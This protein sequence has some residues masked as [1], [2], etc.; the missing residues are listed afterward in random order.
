MAFGANNLTF[1][2]FPI[3]DLMNQRPI[4]KVRIQLLEIGLDGMVNE[5]GYFVFLNIADRLPKNNTIVITSF[6]K[7]YRDM[8]FTVSKDKLIKQH[9]ITTKL[10]PSSSYPFS[11]DETLIR[12]L[13][14]TDVDLGDGNII[15][16]PV[17]GAKVKIFERGIESVTDERGEYVI[18]F[19]SLSKED[20]DYEE[21]FINM[22]FDTKFDLVINS[23]GFREFRHSNIQIEV[24]KTTVINAK[25]L[26]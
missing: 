16:S 4:G 7:Y 11:R 13:V 17:R 15:S 8:I 2:V 22:D 12:G 20:L 14:T 5:D 25:L 21:K 26:R 6:E 19:N 1:S 23:I 18:Y 10:F 3:D 24:L 9:V